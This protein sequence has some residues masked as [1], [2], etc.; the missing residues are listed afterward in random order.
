MRLLLD[1]NLPK[2]LKQDFVEHDIFTIR[3]MQWQGITNGK[4]LSLLLENK[5]D[6]LLTFDKNLEFQQNFL[7]YPITVF[8]LHAS[9]NSY[10]ELSKLSDQIHKVLNHPPLR[11]GAIVISNK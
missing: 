1:E 6:A 8:V 5:F 7:K 11:I 3:E 2:K 10:I 4:L 9:I